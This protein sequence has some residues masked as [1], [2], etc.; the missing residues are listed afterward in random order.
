[1]GG[2]QPYLYNP[3]ATYTPWDPYNGFNPKAISQAS[4]APKPPSQPKPEGPLVS[5]NRHPD[6]YLVTPYGK[7]NVDPMHKNTA[8]RVKIAKRTQLALRCLG[9]I[10]A[11]GILVCVICLK[12]PK[13]SEGWI[14]RIPV[15]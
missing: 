15:S 12:V 7:T 8:R 1:M 5:F 14:I 13:S 11:L 10:G 9:L 4:L 6:S 3:P 2:G